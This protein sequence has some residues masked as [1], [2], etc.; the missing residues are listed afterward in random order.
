MGVNARSEKTGSKL[1]E[2][3]KISISENQ[4]AVQV[5]NSIEKTFSKDN[6]QIEL[7]KNHILGIK[8]K[9]NNP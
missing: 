5:F 6:Y 9:Y 8:Q 3:A 1:W 4:Y 2:Y 7:Q